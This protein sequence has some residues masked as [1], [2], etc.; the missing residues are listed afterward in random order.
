MDAQLLDK[1]IA[2]EIKN[3]INSLCIVILLFVGLVV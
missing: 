1:I 3:I 2:K